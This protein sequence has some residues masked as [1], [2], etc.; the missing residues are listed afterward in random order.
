MSG[1]ESTDVRLEKIEVLLSH[2]QH[3]VDKLN[4]ALISQQAE[5]GGLKHSLAKLESAVDQIPQPP[6]SPLDERPPHY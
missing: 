2:L 3:D 4:D 1:D 5:I 6:R